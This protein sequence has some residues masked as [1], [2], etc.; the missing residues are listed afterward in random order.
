MNTSTLTFVDSTPLLHSP[1]ELRTRADEDGFLFFKQFLPKEPLLELRR[2]ILDILCSHGWVKRGT[3]L[4]DGIAD[5]K[6][7][8]CSD[9]TE[10]RL[11]Y[12]G[13]TKEVYR[14]I[15]MLESFHR[16]PHHPELLSL[17]RALF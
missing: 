5:L 8:A 6:A 14:E 13:V 15:Q 16:L 11:A 1:M 10:G 17:Y 2:Q 9:G 3:D 7:T 12:T 4:M